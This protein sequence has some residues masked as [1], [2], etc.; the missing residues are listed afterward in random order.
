MV[1]GNYWRIFTLPSTIL[2]YCQWFELSKPLLT[3]DLNCVNFRTKQWNCLLFFFSVHDATPFCSLIPYYV[4][5]LQFFEVYCL[6]TNSSTSYSFDILKITIL[7][8]L[9][10]P[11]WRSFDTTLSF[12]EVTSA[13]IKNIVSILWFP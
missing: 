1:L 6:L 8:F 2:M 12:L 9:D 4:E 10:T 3:V 7:H 11:Y 13:V 5:F